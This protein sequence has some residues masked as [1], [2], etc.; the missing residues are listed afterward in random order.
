MRLTDILEYLRNIL[1]ICLFAWISFFPESI[2]DKYGVYIKIFLGI[3]LFILILD[4]RIRKYLFSFRDWPLWLFILSMSA[5]II[6]ATD[7][8]IAFK[9]YAYLAITLA[10]LFYIGKGLFVY[11]LDSDKVSLIICICSGLVA[12]MGVL[13]LYFCKNILYE[14]FIANPFYRRYIMNHRPMSTQ[15]NPVILGGYLLGCLPFNFYLLRNKTFYIRL[16]GILS[17]LLSIAVII[18]TFSRGVF[19]GLISLLVFY[20]W[21]ENK[22]NILVLFLYFMIVLVSVCSY[23]KN[24]NIQRFGFNRFILGSY[25]SM[26]SEYRLSRVNMTMRILKDYPLFGIGFN[27]FRLR[28]GEYCD[29]KDVNEIYE[30][31]IPDNMYLTFLAE[32]GIVGTAGFLIFIVLLLKRG[33]S[34]FRKLG[35]NNKKQMLLIALSALV[36]FLVNMGSYELFYWNNPFMIFCLL[37][38]FVYGSIGKENCE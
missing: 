15:L 10:M 24:V 21:G 5:G 4:K 1:F 31:K 38:G 11:K 13:E 20:L 3:F 8:N 33:L 30:F 26:V 27:H 6:F 36:G 2:Q 14:Y 35:D 12:F 18:L 16:L 22:K 23:Q 37:C 9:T 25:D 32:T 34:C 28:F 19:L 17:I 29:K 7:K